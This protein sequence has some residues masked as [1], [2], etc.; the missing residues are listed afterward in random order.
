MTRSKLTSASAI[1]D[2]LARPLRRRVLLPLSL[3]L[4]LLVVA[5]A[6]MW[7]VDRQ[8]TLDDSSNRLLLVASGQLDMALTIQSEALSSLITLIARDPTMRTALA[9]GDRAVLLAQYQPMFQDLRAAHDITHFYFHQP[10][11]TNLLRV[12]MPGRHGDLIDRYTART[13]A[14]TGAES[15]GIELGPLGTF[16]LRVVRPIEENGI[17]IGF[18]ELGMEIEH[19]LNALRTRLGSDLTVLVDKQALTRV[20]WEAGMIMLGRTADWTR[21]PNHALVFTTLH[22][23]PHTL[24]QAIASRPKLPQGIL[25]R[26]TRAGRSWHL[27]SLPLP[28]A[29]GV[30]HAHLLVLR[31][32]TEDVIA[33]RA[34]LALA[35]I[36]AAG[37]LTVLLTG[38]YLMLRRADR[39]VR[40][41]Q[42]T[43]A[44]S[45]ERL[46]LATRAAGIGVWDW[47]AST[48]ALVWDDRM[49]RMY[50]IDPATFNATFDAWLSCL[51]PNDRARIE[52]EAKEAL[53][54]S[55]P[56]DATFR[57]IRADGQIRHLQAS[58]QIFGNTDGQPARLVGVNYDITD[59]VEAQRQRDALLAAVE[60]SNN[61]IV[62]KDT[63]LRVVA[64]NQTFATATGHDHLA[65]IL[66]KTEAEIF[67]VDPDSEPVRT[68]MADDRRAQALPRGQAIERDAP[69]EC[70][71]G[72]VRH[73]LTRK[74]PLY[75]DKGVLLGTGTISV[76]FTERKRLETELAASEQRFRDVVETLSDWVWEVDATGRMIYC[77]AQV[78][79][80]LGYTPEEIVGH[81]PVDFVDDESLSTFQAVVHAAR[82]GKTPIRDLE[83]WVRTRDGQRVC[84]IANGVPILDSASQLVG[85]RGANSD[86]T[87]RKLMEDSLILRDR[88]LAATANGIAIT[89][90]DGDR[91]VV[92]CNPAFERITGFTSDDVLGLNLRFLH[93]DDIDQAP[94]HELRG[95][96][97]TGFAD[98]DS[99]TGL[100]RNYRKDGSLFWNRLSVAPVRDHAGQTTHFVGVQEDVS[101]LKQRELELQEAREQ[102]DRANRAKSDFLAKMSHELRTPLNAVI[103]FSEVMKE[104]LF[105]PLGS[106]HYK[107][108]VEHIHVS[109]H[110]L[111]ALI[112]DILDMSKI[113]AGRM[114]L[115]ETVVRLRDVLPTVLA[116]CQDSAAKRNLTVSV[117]GVEDLP[118]FWADVRAVKQM[119]LNLISNAIKFTPEG[120]SI[121]I[122]GG[123]DADGTLSVSV[124]DTGV[125]IAESEQARVMEPFQQSKASLQAAEPGSGLGL[126]LV[127]AMIELHRG[128][129]SL[130]SREGQGTTVTL[131]FPPA[132]VGVAA[133]PPSST[134]P[135]PPHAPGTPDDSDP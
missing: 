95:L 74:Y 84:V 68:S 15:A 24:D 123:H 131:R 9:A 93:R 58:A 77:S 113:E 102:A 100:V 111:L 85:F 5:A 44:E 40:S 121:V 31:D 51:H 55:G 134:S 124:S 106:A 49:F 87:R 86:I 103:G 69:V 34:Q 99:F 63:D 13:A 112:N 94:L 97:D 59:R 118:T 43:L 126:A 127:R 122:S 132:R 125:G 107:D 17:R 92:Y 135:M 65:D 53:A 129:I 26:E 10:D 117:D 27:L 108:Y 62:V 80:V 56:F 2:L 4:V 36:L 32:V 25:A 38:L 54:R 23:F 33:S 1:A 29:S 114:E 64:T 133:P 110:Y 20:D 60:N 3:V 48:G 21:F 83:H 41:Q 57:A 82:A 96:L 37:T 8:R 104:E 42:A 7:I 79:E 98:C 81:Y 50:G 67:G 71:D 70:P 52:A 90:A 11:R 73:L 46:S 119:I 72:E 45:E 101:D 109:G 66:G 47:D 28:S 16:T 14:E 22:E 91:P 89:R 130:V 12:H 115:N 128:T 116:V 39:A 88:A 19:I 61:V 18:I 105:G 35:V 30:V 76:D 120:G 78:Q 75:D 6:T